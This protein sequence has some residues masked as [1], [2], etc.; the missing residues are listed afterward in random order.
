MTGSLDEVKEGPLSKDLLQG[1]R[2]LHPAEQFILRLLHH[3]IA[4]QCFNSQQVEISTFLYFVYLFEF[5]LTKLSAEKSAYNWEVIGTS[6]NTSMAL[7]NHSCD[8]NTFR[9]NMDKTS[10]VISSR[11]IR[12]GEEITTAYNGVQFFSTS[13]AKREHSLLKHYM[14]Q[15]ECPACVQKWPEQGNLED[16]LIRVPNFEQVTSASG[17]FSFHHFAGAGLRRSPWGQRENL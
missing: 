8:P 16:E 5:Q 17:I 15:C 10:V 12:A 11:H 14:F 13:L 2:S 1:D 9:F 3:L 6:I 7:I 4:V